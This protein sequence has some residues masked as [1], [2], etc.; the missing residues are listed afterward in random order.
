MAPGEVGTN[1]MCAWH[2]PGCLMPIILLVPPDGVREA[3][4]SHCPCG[5]GLLL[6]CSV[7]EGTG[8]KEAQC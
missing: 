4:E 6:H 1:D 3:W 7:G 8:L 5:V 2:M